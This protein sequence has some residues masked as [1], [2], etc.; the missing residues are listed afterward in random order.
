M[1]FAARLLA[2]EGI[3]LTAQYQ[4]P[5]P[6][7]LLQDEYGDVAIYALPYLKPALVRHWNPEADI[8]SYEEAVSY[9]LGQWAVDKT[10]RNVLLAHQFVTGGVTCESEERSVGGVDQIPAPLFAAFEIRGAYEEV[11]AKSFYQG[12][13]RED[14]LH[15]IL[16]D[17]EDVPEAM[18][19]LRTIYPNLMK[20]SYDNRRTQGVA[21]VTGAERPEEKT[22]LELFQDFYRLQ[23]NQP[24]APQQEALVRQLMETIWEGTQ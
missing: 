14:Y 20:L 13:N 1:A 16:T 23:N 7:F 5:Q 22:P 2:G 3:H 8:A 10:R 24:M 19:K 4:G 9:A 6:P 18:G 11:T 12:T 21:E 15:V 17:E